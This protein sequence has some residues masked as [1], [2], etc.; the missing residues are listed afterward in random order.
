MERGNTELR[1]ELA[2]VLTK[3]LF[4]ADKEA[5]LARLEDN[6]ASPDLSELVATLPKGCLFAAPHDVMDT[7]GMSSPE[8]SR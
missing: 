5:L 1:S 4:P 8:T 6:D 2:R 7:L 3:D